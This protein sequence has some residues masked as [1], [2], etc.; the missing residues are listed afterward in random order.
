MTFVFPEDGI[1][2]L[3]GGFGTTLENDFGKDLSTPLWSASLVN[4]EPEAAV[5]VHL[6]FLD[7]GADLIMTSTYQCAFET[8]RRAGYTDADATRLMRK[9]VRLA[10]QAKEQFLTDVKNKNGQRKI[11]VVL[12]LGPYGA[13]LPPMPMQEFE[14]FY[15]PSYGPQKYSHDGK[16]TT[17]F[18]A[19][20]DE[21][22]RALERAAEK[23]LEEFHFDRLKVFVDDAAGDEGGVWP[24]IDA[25]AFETVP[26]AREIRAIRRAMGRLSSYL[27]ARGLAVKPWWISTVWPNGCFPQEA[28]PG[29]ERLSA[30]DVVLALLAEND[31]DGQDPE[32]ISVEFPSPD[33]IGINCTHVTDLDTI[34]SGLRVAVEDSRP[35][36]GKK[37]FVVLYPNGGATYDV[38]SHNWVSAGIEEGETKS[39]APG[40]WAENLAAIVKR[41]KA[42][43]A[44]GGV[45]RVCFVKFDRLAD[46]TAQSGV[47]TDFATRRSD[48]VCRVLV[49]AYQPERSSPWQDAHTHGFL[50][51]PVM[52]STLTLHKLFVPECQLYHNPFPRKSRRMSGASNMRLVFVQL[53]LLCAWK[54]VLRHL[55]HFTVSTIPSM[56]TPTP[57]Y[58]TFLPLLT[59]D[60]EVEFVWILRARHY[61]IVA[62]FM[63]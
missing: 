8:F 17:A 1:L 10:F 32:R 12:G 62:I 46:G 55:A 29:G 52:S 56:T 51:A 54:L 48:A 59:L 18:R 63:T 4:T 27:G 40:A 53:S 20:S 11:S 47:G 26:L 36:I 14:G 49:H 15:P 33:G 28:S 19:E 5:K 45:F 41:E 42:S 31:M 13:T 24:L 39:P 2:L 7:A 38:A 61:F 30:E 37:P 43:G 9:S 6:A 25:I 44:W 50:I 57:R 22:R 60:D 3:D 58:D 16:N 21:D 35:R 23:A 34:V